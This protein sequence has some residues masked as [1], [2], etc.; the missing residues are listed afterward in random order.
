MSLAN[1]I[2]T[3]VHGGN[4]RLLLSSVALCIPTL[5][6]L[7][8]GAYF[9]A[10]DVPRIEQS[11][12]ESVRSATL[13]MAEAL[14]SGAEKPDF[15]WEY[16]AGIVSGAERYAAE[17]PKTMTWKEW[18][19]NGPKRKT[20]MW[21]AIPRREGS[22]VWVRDGC[23]VYGKETDIEEI[24]Y[25]TLFATGGAA[26]V[27]IL[28]AMTALAVRYFRSYV[29]SRDDY[30]S[31]TAH[32]LAT[33]LVG[34]RL[35]I[36][37]DDEE[38]KVLNERL[39]RIVENIKDF[40]RPGGRRRRPVP[41]RFDLMKAFREAYGLFRED[42]RDLFDGRDLPVDVQEPLE[43]CADETM[44]VQILWNLLGNDLKYAAPFGPV[45]VSARR[46]G[47]FAVMDF[48][49]EGQG[50][51]PRQMRRAFDRY[52]RARSVL[53]SGKGGFGIGLCTS[54]EAASEMGGSLS[55]R[56]NSPKG[57]VFTLRL[58]LAGA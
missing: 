13:D 29:K 2:S 51:T 46:E 42:Y 43:V 7:A 48:I 4:K 36:G 1:A 57:C 32:D 11:E 58:P 27:L 12:R 22:L 6:L 10:V 52:Y 15:T 47:S 33:P 17:F 34:M 35:Y 31:A 19:S 14:K 18:P 53:Q 50:M 38:A 54:R 30:L 44:T 25:R 23:S 45:K 49:D 55:V 37:R 28:L 16:N 56:A 26:T 41:S 9:F 5:M 39:I 20:E 24:D 3:A 40:L 21:G 8:A